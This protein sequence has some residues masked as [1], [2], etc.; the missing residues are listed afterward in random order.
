MIIW[1]TGQPASGKTTLAQRLY[2]M[3]VVDFIIDGDQLR[4]IH[5]EDY[6]ERG[7]HANVSR[8][9]DIALYLHNE[10]QRVAVALVSPY[11]AQREWM[12]GKA[13]VHEFYLHT[14]EIR[15]REHFFSEHYQPPDDAVVLDTGTLTEEE[16]VRVIIGS[17]TGSA[18]HAA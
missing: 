14:E 4:E 16:C 7:R 18:S 1:L 13:P 2:A 6:D 5:P 12:K 11:V 17:V 15:G 3:G 8:A 9:Q 10:G